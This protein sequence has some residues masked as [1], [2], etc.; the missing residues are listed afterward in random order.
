MS[1]SN[2]LGGI[3]SF[4]TF[5]FSFSLQAEMQRKQEEI[6]QGVLAAQQEILTLQNNNDSVEVGPNIEGP[7][8]GNT[9]FTRVTNCLAF[10]LTKKWKAF[11]KAAV[12][13]FHRK[14]TD[15]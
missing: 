8:I 6:S 14:H 10:D 9:H 1:L 4:I 11:N 13:F 5:F 7:I 12:V 2:V 3:L 15:G